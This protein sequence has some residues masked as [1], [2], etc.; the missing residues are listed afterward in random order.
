MSSSATGSLGV[1][2][3]LLLL[4]LV[5]RCGVAPGRTRRWG[6]QTSSGDAA[7]RG[8]A[9]CSASACLRRSGSLVMKVSATETRAMIPITV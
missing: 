8:Q 7:V 2:V 1:V 3:M 9:A 6:G 4:G 5:A